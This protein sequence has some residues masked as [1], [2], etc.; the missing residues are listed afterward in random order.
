MNVV[1]GTVIELGQAE[2]VSITYAP[3]NQ[4]SDDALVLIGTERDDV[5]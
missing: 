3:T 1:S 4:N 2:T 5:R